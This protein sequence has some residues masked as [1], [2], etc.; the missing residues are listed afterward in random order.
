VVDINALFAQLLDLQKQ[1]LED[2]AANRA[3]QAANQQFQAQL[4][5]SFTNQQQIQADA[6]AARAT[7]LAEAETARAAARADAAKEP[8]VERPSKFSGDKTKIATFF[9]AVQR[10]FNVQPS[11]FLTEDRKV[12][13]T[14][15]LLD[16]EAATGVMVAQEQDTP[17]PWLESF[18]LLKAHLLETHGDP[19]AMLVAA[20]KLESLVQTGSASEYLSKR[21]YL[22]LQAGYALDSTQTVKATCDRLKPELREKLSFVPAYRNGLGF[23]SYAE[24][25]SF[26]VPLETSISTYRS[27][28]APTLRGPRL[29]TAP[30]YTSIGRTLSAPAPARTLVDAP[31]GIPPLVPRE[32]SG[33]LAN[34]PELRER[35]LAAGRCFVCRQPGH[36][37]EDCPRKR[38]V[39]T[40][41]AGNV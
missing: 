2:Q 1:H 41:P 29:D 14:L 34:N 10:V 17:P 37:A 9:W 32:F 16:G 15:Q 18:D 19:D 5:A 12:A 31:V 3:M 25:T 36:S 30:P 23:K 33:P 27:M 11:R 8:D 4:F 40:E 13:Y 21:R 28:V 26:I 38:I 22:I 6:E 7:A 20:Q 35:V 39:K 24:L